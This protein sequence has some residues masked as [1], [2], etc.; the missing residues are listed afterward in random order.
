MIVAVTFV[1]VT[2]TRTEAAQR[3]FDRWS[4][5]YERD[6]ASRW[7][8]EV[9]SSALQALDL[10]ARDSLLDIA[11]GTGAAV[12]EAAP[13]VARA[14]GLDLSPGMIAQ[15]RTL[16]AALGNVEFRVVD[17]TA[18]LPFGD[19]EFTAILCTT[20]FHHFPAPLEAI[21]EMARVLAADGRLVIGD[22]NSDRLLVRVLDL[23]LRTLQHSHVGCPSASALTRDL[24]AA[25]FAST[26]VDTMWLGSYAV[27]RG[28]KTAPV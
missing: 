28:A 6:T 23:G 22:M 26:A 10:G 11:C 19:G 14:V 20:A 9:Q 4:R 18:G 15:A 3:H 5:T 21:A 12:R 24:R 16:A 13:T 8:R 2:D 7:L 1:V 17:V 27:V 25:G